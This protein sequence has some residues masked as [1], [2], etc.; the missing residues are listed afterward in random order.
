MHSI[1]AGCILLQ[2]IPMICGV[3]VVIVYIGVIF[4][5]RDSG[6]RGWSFGM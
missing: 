2:A 5:R 3:T 1:A 4:F 6:V